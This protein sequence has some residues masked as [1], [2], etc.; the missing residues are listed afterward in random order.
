CIKSPFTINVYEAKRELCLRLTQRPGQKPRPATISP[1]AP[2]ELWLEPTVAPAAMLLWPITSEAQ[3]NELLW[4][5]S[6]AGKM[7][8]FSTSQHE[9]VLLSPRNELINRAPYF[10]WENDE[11]INRTAF[12]P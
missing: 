6:C 11:R 5:C 8:E 2:R 7:S 9:M 3:R 12:T 1:S 4:C 10:S